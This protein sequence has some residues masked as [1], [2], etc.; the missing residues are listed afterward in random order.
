MA[1]RLATQRANVAVFDPDPGRQQLAHHAGLTLAQD[2][3]HLIGCSD[4]VLVVVLDA[5]QLNTLLDAWLRPAEALSGKVV[6][7]CSTIAP[8]QTLIAASRLHQAGAEVL[9]APVSGGPQRALEGALSVMLA[10]KPSVIHRHQAWMPLLFSKQVTISEQIGDATKAKLV[11]NFLAGLHLHAA[12]QAF[13]LVKRLGLEPEQMLDLIQSS[14]GQSW[15]LGDR[16]P[17]ALSDDLVPRAQLRVLTKDLA[18]AVDL[19]HRY[20]A[21]LS[22]GEHSLERYR[23]ACE[24]GWSLLDDA[25]LVQWAMELSPKG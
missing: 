23:E 19:A 14:S 20:G 21:N 18:L 25:G 4:V 17:R 7:L 9:D 1:R 3:R 2:A 12:A 6:F 5:V 11:N 16:V 10:G 8:E 22:L 24:Q 13:G 15:M